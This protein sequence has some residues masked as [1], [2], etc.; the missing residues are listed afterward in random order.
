MNEA[1]FKEITERVLPRFGIPEG[2]LDGQ[3]RELMMKN[4]GKSITAGLEDYLGQD[5]MRYDIT[6]N[7]SANKPEDTNIYLNTVSVTMTK[8]DGEIRK[9][10]FA[11][12]PINGYNLDQINNMMDGRS[13]YKEI[14]SNKD[15]ETYLMWYALDLNKKDEHG[16]NLPSRTFENSS[17]F[18]LLIEVGKIPFS[19][20]MTPLEKETMIRN[21]RDGNEYR[22]SL[23]LPDGSIKPAILVSLPHINQV[24]A[25]D[26]EGTRIQ[27]AKKTMQ[28]VPISKT[29]QAVMQGADG[30]TGKT[31]SSKQKAG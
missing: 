14:T 27:L 22:T 25:Y 18:N 12:Y 15:N 7:R 16:K 23:K 1:N 6:F 2:V 31:Q 24:A 8:A 5:H 20:N 21:L 17:N 10:D 9:H 30:G 19:G 4:P 26:L 11:I 3:I 29:T 13:V 28:A